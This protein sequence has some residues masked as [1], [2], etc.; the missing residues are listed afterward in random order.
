[1]MRLYV[2]ATLTLLLV[3]CK[4]Q[5]G[6]GGDDPNAPDHSESF[7]KGADISWITEFES[8]GIKFYNTQGVET[9]C[10][11]IMKELGMNT[12][13]L[14][15]WVD[16]EGGWNGID[17]VVRKAKRARDLGM[18]V[19]VDFHYSD[20]WADPGKQVPPV[21]WATYNIE[22]LKVAVFDHTSEVLE[23]LRNENI[24]VRW[25][26]VGNETRGGMLYPLG[27]IDYDNSNFADLVSSG[28]DATKS[29]YAD[30]QV[31][32][33][34]DSGDQLG[35]YT[36]VFDY[37]RNYNARYDMIG[38]SLY[39]TPDDWQS[40]ANSLIENIITLKKEYSK[41]T[42]ICEIGMHYTEVEN[43]Y[44]LVS[45][46]ILNGRNSTDGACKG[47]LYWEPE[48]HPSYSAG[49]DKGAFED[50]KPTFALSAFGR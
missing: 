26:Q 9:E 33:H 18:A 46:L 23:A 10:T 39:P 21:A 49:Y 41:P 47:V 2:I 44:R 38:M 35:L 50:G 37:L 6:G 14:R 12:I 29:I 15:V 24:D 1:M 27:A 3:S 31:I 16:P 4:Q 45:Y 43:C 13:R 32:V 42:I 5:N 19:M 20:S 8:N 40:A 22:E 34:I 25:V 30:A 17:D 11:A 7:A 36:Y 28:Y 48:S